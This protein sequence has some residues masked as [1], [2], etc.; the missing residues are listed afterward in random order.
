MPMGPDRGPQDQRGRGSRR[1]RETGDMGGRGIGRGRGHRAGRG[2]G[3]RSRRRILFFA[4]RFR[5]WADG[6]FPGCKIRFGGS[7]RLISFVGRER[8]RRLPAFRRLGRGSGG[9]WPGGCARLGGALRRVVRLLFAWA[10]V[11]SLAPAAVVA[12]VVVVGR[13]I[14]T[15]GGRL[16]VKNFCD[17]RERGANDRHFHIQNGGG[18]CYH[19]I[20]ILI[21]GNQRVFKSSA[22]PLVAGEVI[23]GPGFLIPGFVVQGVGEDGFFHPRDPGERKIGAQ[24]AVAVDPDVGGKGELPVPQHVDGEFGNG[25]VHQD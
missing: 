5:R 3:N 16:E 12:A 17:P 23:P 14:P 18:F 20:V 2:I 24:I 7:A 21:R 10:V 15:P 9:L 6:I 13:H 8:L 11:F 4:C 25:H 19:R 22:L 1:R